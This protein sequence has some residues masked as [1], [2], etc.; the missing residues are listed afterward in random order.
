MTILSDLH[1]AAPAGAHA[2]PHRA[3]NIWI[4]TLF[5]LGVAAFAF[6]FFTYLFLVGGRVP[7][8]MF[9]A[10]GLLLAPGLLLR[11]WLARVGALV[12]M[13]MCVI[14]AMNNRDPREAYERRMMER[15][16]ELHLP[17]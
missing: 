5:S 4:G 7:L 2:T 12:L 3:R 1:P 11:S 9:V 17:N 10:T 13:I 15:Y 8:W 6:T 14:M 16:R